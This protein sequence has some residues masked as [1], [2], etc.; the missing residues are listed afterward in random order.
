MRYSL[1][2]F[3]FSFLFYMGWAPH[4]TRAQPSAANAQ[5]D[6]ALLIVPVVLSAL[7]FPLLLLLFCCFVLL[8]CHLGNDRRLCHALPFCASHFDS[9]TLPLPYPSALLLN[10]PACWLYFEGF[11]FFWLRHFFLFLSSMSVS[12]LSF[13]FLFFS[14]LS[15]NIV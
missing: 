13:F 8:S 7:H 11:Y 15:C 9:T 5:R 1:Y 10:F 14:F 4:P 6:D 12:F 3:F 2:W